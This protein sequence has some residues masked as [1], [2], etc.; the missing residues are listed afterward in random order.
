M[1][2]CPPSSPLDP[3]CMLSTL[4]FSGEK[5]LLR[6]PIHMAT[7]HPLG[8]PS[9]SLTLFLSCCS[10][11]RKCPGLKQKEMER[12]Q[13]WKKGALYTC[14]AFLGPSYLK[15]VLTSLPPTFLIDLILINLP[16][17][18]PLINPWW[19]RGAGSEVKDAIEGPKERCHRPQDSA[20][21]T[22]PGDYIL[23]SSF[24]KT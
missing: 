4:S 7:A 8:K 16:V 23:R 5:S 12:K 2:C 24:L 11:G 18:P 21:R 13:S 10:I 15:P 1:D 9:F 22:S 14:K 20:G 17:G 6:Y 3:F 19:R